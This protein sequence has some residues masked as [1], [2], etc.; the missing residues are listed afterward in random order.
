[1][2]KVLL[3]T[4]FAL[5]VSCQNEIDIAGFDSTVSTRSNQCISE[6]YY[7]FRHEKITLEK[8][9][10]YSYILFEE[11]EKENLIRKLLA[12][13]I[14]FSEESI[15]YIDNE[16]VV[17][18]SSDISSV[19][20]CWMKATMTEK[21]ADSFSEI[22]YYG[23]YYK[24]GDSTFPLTH[25]FYVSLRSTSDERLLRK[26]SEE[27]GVTIEG[28]YTSIPNL[29]VLSC[30][31]LSKGNALQMANLFEESG[32]FEYTQP[33]FM[34]FKPTTNDTYFSRQW[35]LRNTGQNSGVSGVDIK[36][37]QAL[38][39]IPSTSNIVVG[40]IDSGIELTHPDL[41][42][43][44][45]S[46]D[47]V[48]SHS[49]S[50]IHS[51]TE[52]A[53]MDHGTNV[54]G[55]ISAKRNNNSGIAGVASPVKTMSFS[56]SY[57]NNTSL[58]IANAIRKAADL[59]ISVINCSFASAG[60]EN[61]IDSAIEYA[62]TN[63][64]NGKGCVIVCSTGNSNTP[65]LSFPAN[66]T[67]ESRVIAV[68]AIKNNG[69][70]LTYPFYGSN[71]GT[72]LDLVAPGEDIPTT[73]RNGG[74][75]FSFSGTS[76]AAPHVSAAAAL[77]L[78]INPDLTYNEVEFILTRSANKALSSYVFSPSGHKGSWNQQV[79]YGLLDLH[80]ALTMA[81]STTGSNNLNISGGGAIS[82]DS[83]GYAYGSLTA[84]PNN[85]SYTYLWSGEF[86]GSCDRWYIWPASSEYGPS[87]DVS[88]YLNPGQPGGTLVVNCY[89]FNGNTYIGKA[90]T[91][92]YAY[93]SSEY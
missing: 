29:Y 79:G 59:G 24:A 28:A 52:S 68:G 17:A 86:L 18:K 50:Q 27:N 46:W 23:P 89:V 54:A 19:R 13:G 53:N 75:T 65:Y 72:G 82:F 60:Y 56:I 70:R 41:N 21:D 63:G 78:S 11:T 6:D 85:Y 74:Y 66:T 4:L 58:Y 2:K 1:M 67:P 40:V 71:F 62:T 30:D 38:S 3:L 10:R 36:F 25:Q 31:K 77:V 16:G 88:I 92:L 8:S 49:P 12:K 76:A 33:V 93:S 48:T 22:I 43:Y 37:N 61:V 7:Y 81:N 90:S 15:T 55:I 83:S 45:S 47:A 91:Y 64:R 39:L 87:V 32:L 14:D 5:F 35:N 80:A 9:S 84:N 51:E 44:S 20:K 73:K 69:V 57:S 34:S 26:L 42:L